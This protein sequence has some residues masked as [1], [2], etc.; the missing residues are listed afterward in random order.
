MYEFAPVH[1][2]GISF[3]RTF[4]S[5]DTQFI[6][7]HKELAKENLS[8]SRWKIKGLEGGGSRFC[9]YEQGKNV[10]Q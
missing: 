10:I 8:H 5:A 2:H 4:H 6:G 9:H 1:V 3:T 7:F